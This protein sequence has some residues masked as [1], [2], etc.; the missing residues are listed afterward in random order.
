MVRESLGV[1]VKESLAL[2]LSKQ[3]LVGNLARSLGRAKK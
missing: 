1:W 3:R 2:H